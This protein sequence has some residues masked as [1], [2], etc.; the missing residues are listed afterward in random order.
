M[1]TSDVVHT[2]RQINTI[3]DIEFAFVDVPTVVC[4]VITWRTVTKVPS[5]IVVTN[6]RTKAQI[7]TVP[8]RA[9]INVYAVVSCV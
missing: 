1:M 6:R 7:E 3:V 2:L 9:L 8:A 4:S 5:V